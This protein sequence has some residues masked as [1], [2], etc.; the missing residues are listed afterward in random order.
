MTAPKVTLYWVCKTGEGWKR[1]PAA[2]G[3]NGKIRPRFAQIG[4]AQQF[5]EVGHYE[6]RFLEGGKTVWKNVGEDAAVADASQLALAKTLTARVSAKA[7]GTTIVEAPGRVHLKRKADD[8]KARQIT[9]GKKRA[10]V[11][12]GTAIAGFLTAVKV[13][14]ADELTEAH[15]LRWY[16]ALQKIKNG[17]RAIYNKHISV[18]GF[19][20]WAK[21]DT[22]KL[23]EKAP[24]YTKKKVEVYKKPELK[25]FFDSL[26]DDY[27]RIVFL[28]L[29]KT[30]LRMQEAM[31]LEWH[32]FDF[33]H[34]TLAVRER[35]E[36]GFEIK[37]REERVL[38]IPAELIAALKVWKKEHGGK[39]VLGTRNDTV[40]WKW[41]PLLKRLVRD[42]GL[43]CGHCRGC[44]EKHKEC[45]HWNIKR[46]RSTY[47]TFLLR[48][49]IDAR[50]VM[51]YTG[52]ADLATVLLYLE[53]AELPETQTKINTI[54]WGD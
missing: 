42:A 44:R 47:T 49:G 16:A 51:K 48:S 11:T 14:Y 50:T 12:F 32:Q 54:N 13:T 26:T 41:L 52:H 39:L 45:E 4:N 17:P 9:R 34:G 25:A 3:R 21:V 19:L 28:V 35:T 22:K 40:N 24:T 8:F 27:H 33:E 53:A 10:A 29:L 6:C 43:N 30:G 36:D 1:Y 5:I 2:W 31:H 23:A 37:D 18:F 15:I 46:F 7:A 20:K 38:P